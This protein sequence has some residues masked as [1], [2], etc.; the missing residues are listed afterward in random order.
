MSTGILKNR[1]ISVAISLLAALALVLSTMAPLFPTGK[2]KPA[3]AAAGGVCK[4]AAGLASP[5]LSNSTGTAMVI[6]VNS[7]ST[8]TLRI[9]TDD[10]VDGSTDRLVVSRGTV[11]GNAAG[12]NN[13]LSA[14]ATTAV[15]TA[16][17]FGFSEAGADI[18]TP[19]DAYNQFVFVAPTLASGSH[20]DAGPVPVRWQQRRRL[21]RQ[22]RLT[23]PTS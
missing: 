3:F 10:G 17:P 13:F 6:S 5:I 14:V 21:H 16:P 22:Q 7:G 23:P 20:G 19:I 4:S 1:G 2:I 9:Y 11:N 8:T 18:A 12:T 15:C